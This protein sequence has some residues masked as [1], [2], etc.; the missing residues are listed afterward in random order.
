MKSLKINPKLLIGILI[1][2]FFGI[3]LIFRILLPYNQ[4]FVGDWIKFTSNDAYYHMRM[5]DIISHNFPHFA[6]FDPYLIYPGGS[7]DKQ[8][9]ILSLAHRRHYLD[10]RP[11]FTKPSPHRR[12]RRLFPDNPGRPGHHSRLLHR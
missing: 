5:I 3:S 6:K 1:A 11:G 2:A 9:S 12:G 8:Y 7:R 4:V 10:N